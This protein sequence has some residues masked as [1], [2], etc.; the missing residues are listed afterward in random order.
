[1][2]EITFNIY[3]VGPV[4]IN[5]VAWFTVLSVSNGW[6]RSTSYCMH[7]IYQSRAVIWYNNIDSELQLLS[8]APATCIYLQIWYQWCCVPHVML[9]PSKFLAHVHEWKGIWT[10]KLI[11]NNSSTCF[12]VWPTSNGRC[13]ID[14]QFCPLLSQDLNTTWYSFHVDG[15]FREESLML[16]KIAGQHDS[17]HHGHLCNVF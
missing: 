6:W 1:M 10:S 15:Y 14:E 8:V 13:G 12:V 9:T 11:T 4:S 7:L 5:W 16:H 17:I 2:V 3:I